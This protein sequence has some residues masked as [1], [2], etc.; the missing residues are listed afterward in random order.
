ME[1]S[2]SH[3]AYGLLRPDGSGINSSLK[4]YSITMQSYP[5]PK[6]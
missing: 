6:V 4:T 5:T 3:K 2:V 1:A